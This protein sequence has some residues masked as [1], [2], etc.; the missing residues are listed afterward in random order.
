M[1]FGQ[2]MQEYVCLPL[3]F[4][5][6]TVLV[7]RPS[8]IWDRCDCDQRFSVQGARHAWTLLVSGTHKYDRVHNLYHLFV[9][10]IKSL[11]LLKI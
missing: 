6:I 10:Q 11:Y 7:R 2:G 4:K 8:D 3:R 9:G 5:P 1:L